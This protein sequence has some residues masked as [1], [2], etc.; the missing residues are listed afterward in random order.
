[1]MIVL[2]QQTLFQPV[3]ILIAILIKTIK[4]EDGTDNFQDFLNEY[5]IS[6]NFTI[7]NNNETLEELLDVSWYTT[8]IFTL[9]F[10]SLSAIAV[11]GNSLI[12]WIVIKNPKMHNVTNYFICNLAMADIVIGLFAIPFQVNI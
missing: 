7:N 2:H 3:C 10:V 12:I 1:M 5:N 9:L 11:L 6:D 4:S 8:A